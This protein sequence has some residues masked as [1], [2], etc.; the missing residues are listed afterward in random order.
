MSEAKPAIF[1]HNQKKEHVNNQE[2][3]VHEEF[4]R[5]GSKGLTFKYYTKTRGKKNSSYKIKGVE[6]S[7]NKFKLTII[8]DDGDKK[9]FD[10][11][12]LKDLAKHKELKFLVD[13]IKKDM[14]K[15]RK[16]IKTTQSR[17]KSKK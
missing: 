13:Y 9:E 2:K 12:D 1:I 11:V 14:E 3:F 8:K 17:G 10:N 15:F 16:T 5:D 7:K 4:I 6:T